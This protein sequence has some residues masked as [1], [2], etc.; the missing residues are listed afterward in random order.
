MTV[1]EYHEHVRTE[2]ALETLTLWDRAPG[3]EGG[4]TSRSRCRGKAP[5]VTCSWPSAIAPRSRRWKAVASC[6]ARRPR[7]PARENNWI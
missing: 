7:T 3:T 4:E 5:R 2:E 1:T 6:P